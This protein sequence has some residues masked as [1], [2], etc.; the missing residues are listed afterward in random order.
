[1]DEHQI[2]GV[3]MYRKRAFPNL[4]VIICK[5]CAPLPHSSPPR[6]GGSAFLYILRDTN[7]MTL[8]S[9]LRH[10]IQWNY[11]GEPLMRSCVRGISYVQVSPVAKLV[12]DDSAIGGLLAPLRT[13]NLTVNV[14]KNLKEREFT[15]TELERIATSLEAIRRMIMSPSSTPALSEVEFY[16]EDPQPDELKLWTSQVSSR[17]RCLDS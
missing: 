13:S 6:L 11:E 17:A 14:R 4:R 15:Q 12:T 16:I 8:A 9:L 2:A 3:N 7:L 5:E 10:P 1:L